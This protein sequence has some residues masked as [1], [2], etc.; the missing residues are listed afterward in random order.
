M[1][2]Y[3]TNA[4]ANIFGS[5][6]YLHYLVEY[7]GDL[8]GEASN[9]SDIYITI[10]S[11]KYAIISIRLN[12]PIEDAFTASKNPFPSI[13][14]ISRYYYYTLQDLSP[15]VAA[16][17]NLMQIKP[18]VYLTGKGT[19]IG[20]IDTGIDYLNKEFMNSDGTT[21]ILNIWDQSIVTDSPEETVPFGR[22]F[23][24][25][26]INKAITAFNQGKDPYEI[27]PS[28]D[29]IGHGTA[30]AGIT[31]AKGVNPE[32]IGAA[33]DCNFVIIK[34]FEAKTVE[35]FINASVPIYDNA[36]IVMALS[37]LYQY[38]LESNIPL[39]ILLPIGTNFGNHK[40]DG[41]LESIINDLSNNAGIVVVTGSGN[42]GNAAGH[43]SGKIRNDRDIYDVPFI[44][45]KEQRFLAIEIW[46]DKPNV[47]ALE[48]VAASGESSGIIPATLKQFQVSKSIFEN[49]VAS[50][51][52][53][54]PEELSGDELIYVKLMDLT[55]GVWK[56]RLH[57][58]K[59]L[60]LQAPYNVWMQQRGIALGT[61]RFIAPDPY[62]TFT[63]PG[64]A[65]LIITVANYNQNNFNIVASSGLSFLNN[66]FNSVD[67]A[68][69][70]I[71]VKVPGSNN[72][73]NIISGT[74]AAAAVVAGACSIL[75]QWG[76]VKGNDPTMYSQ[77][78][79]YYIS[80]GTQKRANDTYPNAEWGYGVIDILG[81]FKYLE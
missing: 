14:Y 42:E 29:V 13:V 7:N 56:L 68:A 24:R 2:K 5:N 62:G 72:G 71:N 31:G 27:V 25:E 60:D 3:F 45:S 15:I 8:E 77:K 9:S 54:V 41:I 12:D 70:G 44:V 30:M 4:P 78:I 74:S 64:S 35:R 52:Y 37:Y 36:S 59:A 26:D 61:T 47:M 50:I 69:G 80:R 23:S 16:N 1:N 75:L 63:G 10:F 81:V 55:P 57:P 20:I 67:I 39:V 53:F 38:A 65:E 19:I 34:L 33:P 49:T 21:R 73:V 58:V 32:L 43:S 17:I 79:K 40:G 46:V 18:P 11:D 6:E 51:E 66:S 28:K 48:L 22:V 76:I